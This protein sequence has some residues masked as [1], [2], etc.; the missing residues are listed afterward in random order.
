MR[1][2]GLRI[3]P[4]PK[5]TRGTAELLVSYATGV[6]SDTSMMALA[7]AEARDAEAAETCR[8]GP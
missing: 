3:S 8:S 2:G 7:L 6:S 1:E 5:N 4:Y